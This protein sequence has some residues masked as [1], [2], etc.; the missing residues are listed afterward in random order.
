MISDYLEE[1]VVIAQL[2]HEVPRLK[3]IDWKKVLDS[4]RRVNNYIAY[5]IYP[6]N[7]WLLTNYMTGCVE[8]IIFDN[9]LERGLSGGYYEY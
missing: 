6:E 8:D 7:S 3:S 5:F 2:K 1:E 9:N 4:G